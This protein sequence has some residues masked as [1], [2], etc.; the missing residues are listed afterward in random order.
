MES[1]RGTPNDTH[2]QTNCPTNPF[3]WPLLKGC[4][5]YKKDIPP[6]DFDEVIKKLQIEERKKTQADDNSKQKILEK[7]LKILETS[8]HISLLEKFGHFHEKLNEAIIP[9][10]Y[11]GNTFS[12]RFRDVEVKPFSDSGNRIGRLLPPF[13]THIRTKY[14]QYLLR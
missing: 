3:H 6:L 9:F 13:I 14:A 1:I 5:I 8:Y 2:Q 11:R 12:F 10:M 4:V 7:Q